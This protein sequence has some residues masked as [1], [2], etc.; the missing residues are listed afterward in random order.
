MQKID[1]FGGLHGN[2]LELLVNVFIHQNNFDITQPVFTETGACHLKNT[3]DTYLRTTVAG[4]FSYSKSLF[5]VNDKV[6]K[7][8]PTIDDML[9]GITNSFL[10]AGDQIVDINNLEIDTIKKLEKLPKTAKF[11]ESL[12]NDHG[13]QDN[14]SRNILRNYFYSM[15]DVHEYGLKMFTE[16]S[17]DIRCY[18]N[19]PFRALF[20]S[21]KLF[22]ELNNIAKFLELNFYPSEQLMQMHEKFLELNQGH[23]SEIKC[24]KIL[25]CI[26]AGKS[27]GIKLNLIE[28]AW[29]NWQIAR[30]LRCYDLPILIGKQYPTNTLEISKAVFDWKSGDYS[31]VII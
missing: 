26:W 28:E 19:F 15:F 5:D 21:N 25:R 18:C 10:R 6:I 22:F 2:Y 4:H 1:F 9:I 24:A 23:Q 13:T 31:T 14:Y 12:I 17:P 3:Y 16:F 8:V 27:I 20:D 7:I 11:L 29:I 30:S